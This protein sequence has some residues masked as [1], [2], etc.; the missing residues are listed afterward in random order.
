MTDKTETLADRLEAAKAETFRLQRELDITNAD[1]IALWLEANKDDSSL[2]WLACRI[3]EAHEQEMA[4]A[5]LRAQPASD[6][7]AGLVERLRNGPYTVGPATGE[8]MELAQAADML[9]RLAGPVQE[10]FQERVGGWM[11][12]CFTP[13]ITADKLERND[14][15]I[16]EALELVQ[17]CGYDAAR[18]HALVDYVF[19]R[20]VGEPSQEVGGVMVTLAAL[21]NP[22][23]ID[24][25]VAAET[26][27]A[28]I[29]APKVIEK[30][31]AKQASKPTGS[32]LPIPQPTQ[33]PG[34]DQVE[35]VEHRLDHD[36]WALAWYDEAVRDNCQLAWFLQRFEHH[37]LARA[38]LTA[39]N[40]FVVDGME[41]GDREAAE[42]IFGEILGDV[43][44]YAEWGRP[45]Y[46]E[47]AIRTLT[48]TLTAHRLLGQ[49]QGAWGMQW[50]P[51]ETCKMWQVAIVTNGDDVAMA[52]KAEADYGGHYWSIDPEDALEWEPAHWIAPPASLPEEG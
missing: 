51:I 13:E 19:S 29:L 50:Q 20:P 24:M 21:C 7:V 35:A 16:E 48:E 23:G 3:I 41:V 1:H 37:V 32:A 49:Q 22:H 25:V 26:E 17:S 14:R 44:S 38:A 33:Q 8:I 10:P 40:P 27:L 6:E 47:G 34:A 2:A 28:R 5:A 18:A 30:I 11:L 46:R 43:G 31:R 36:E 12:E 9:E 42:R 52:Q 45:S 4:L 15:F 39:L